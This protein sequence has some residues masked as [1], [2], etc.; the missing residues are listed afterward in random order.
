MERT[1]TS[2]EEIISIHFYLI[3]FLK[4][5]IHSSL[6]KKEV[7]MGRLAREYI[8][9]K[10]DSQAYRRELDEWLVRWSKTLET[11]EDEQVKRVLTPWAELNY[12]QGL[13]MISMLWPTPG[14]QPT[15]ICDNISKACLT[16]ARQQQLLANLGLANAKS[17][18]ILAFPM[19]WTTGHL[20]LQVGLHCLGTQNLTSEEQQRRNLSLQRCLGVLST[21]ETDNENLLT[22]QSII[23]EEL[24]ERG[25]II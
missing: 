18:P 11:I 17:E 21:L 1:K 6:L 8:G 19:N 5:K 7:Y 24:W 9:A 13:H 3:S 12:A 16:L 23:F 15:T 2:L 25:N 10:S 4:M 14:G 22:G 20:A